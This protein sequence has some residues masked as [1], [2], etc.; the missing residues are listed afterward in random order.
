MPIDQ[1]SLSEVLV[2]SDGPDLRVS[3]RSSSPYGTLFQ[4]YVNH[5]LSWFGSARACHVPRP[6]VGDGSSI[7]VDVGVV[8]AR[9]LHHDFSSELQSLELCGGPVVLSWPGGTYL[10]AT[11]GDDLLGFRVY[12]SANAGRSFQEAADIPAYPG[13]R[14]SDGFGLGGVG[15]GGFGRSGSTYSWSAGILAS[16]EWTFKVVAYGRAGRESEPAQTVK[17]VVNSPPRPP[18]RYADQSRVTYSYNG[19]VARSL[20]LRW[21]PS[22]SAS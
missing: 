8:E 15:K 4:V 1:S 20:E 21:Q 12:S 17:V 6:P 5:R 9:D 16:G 19:P 18:A 22:P 11:G 14:I 7:W 13:G 10:D 3:W 2:A